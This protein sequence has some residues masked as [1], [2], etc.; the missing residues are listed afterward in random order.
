MT[1]DD[2]CL[3]LALFSIGVLCFHYP[4]SRIL[5]PAPI[6]IFSVSIRRDRPLGPAFF[7]FLVFWFFFVFPA[8]GSFVEQGRDLGGILRD[9]IY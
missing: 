3:H 9:S 6:V 5:I 2:T 4:C 8:V 1:H 7:F